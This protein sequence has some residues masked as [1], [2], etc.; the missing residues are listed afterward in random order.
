MFV[1]SH[2]DMVVRVYC[3][4]ERV[5]GRG[6]PGG[7]IEAEWVYPTTVVR[8]RCNMIVRVCCYVEVSG[9]GTPGGIIIE[10]ERA[11]GSPPMAHKVSSSIAKLITTLPSK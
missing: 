7:I 2:R 3:Y 5:G 11:Y 10:V 1:Q 6:T 9:R 8:S 4:V